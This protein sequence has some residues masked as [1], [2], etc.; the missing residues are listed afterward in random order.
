[1]GRDRRS[2]LLIES[3]LNR[4]CTHTALK[5]GLVQDET[6]Y[7]KSTRAWGSRYDE[8]NTRN[9]YDDDNRPYEDEFGNPITPAEAFIENHGIKP[10]EPAGGLGER[11]NDTMHY[12]RG[13]GS[14]GGGGDLL[15]GLPD[16]DRARRKRE[17]ANR[18]IEYGSGLDEQDQWEADQAARNANGSSGRY[19]GD[20][21]LGDL[22]DPD[23]VARPLSNSRSN[24]PYANRGGYGNDDYSRESRTSQGSVLPATK[25]SGRSKKSERYGIKSD[26]ADLASTGSSNYGR[27]SNSR[28]AERNNDAYDIVDDDR[29]RSSRRTSGEE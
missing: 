26:H 16:E 14:A 3:V 8:R 15:D 23:A 19:T 20:S 13:G 4:C 17:K 1:M 9:A 18:R 5:A 27:S 24:N 11:G 21:L 2:V 22:E 12:Q 28:K 7:I 10:A 25:K 29:R 6:E